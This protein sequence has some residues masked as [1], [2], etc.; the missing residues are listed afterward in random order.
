MYVCAHMCGFAQELMNTYGQDLDIRETETE[1]EREMREAETERE[2]DMLEAERERERC[3][4]LKQTDR[5]RETV[6]TSKTETVQK[7]RD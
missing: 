2:R 6:K 3:V 1:R 7:V 4:K 5:E